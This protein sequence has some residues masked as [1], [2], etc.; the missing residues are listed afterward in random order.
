[1][2]VLALLALG[3][4]AYEFR[5]LQDLRLLSESQAAAATQAE[6][7]LRMLNGQLQAGA[8]KLAAIEAR[9]AEARRNQPRNR[10]AQTPPAAAGAQT[11]EKSKADAQLFLASDPA[12]RGMVEKVARI[13]YQALQGPFFRQQN[14][15]SQQVSQLMDAA[16]ATWIQTLAIRPGGGIYPTQP[17][18][19]ADVVTSILGPDG[20]QQLLTYQRSIPA[21][22]FTQEVATEAGY[23]SAPLTPAQQD[24][25]TEMIA[26]ASG[27]YQKGEGVNLGTV[28]WEAVSNQIGSAGLSPAQ[29]DALQRLIA[30]Q[31]Y[32]AALQ[33]ALRA[34]KTPQ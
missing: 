7:D 18:P 12:L 24:K 15:T 14:L 16:V 17:Q 22:N 31:Q 4:V 11:L 5:L 6:S 21:V 9:Q 8:Q 13:Q 30:N 2:A 25:I 20:Y 1:L 3:A 27:S 33:Q 34:Q 10:Q 32:D 28:N 19:S 23:S 26:G 29:S